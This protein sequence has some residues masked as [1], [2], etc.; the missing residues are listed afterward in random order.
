MQPVEDAVV[1]EP[2]GAGVEEDEDVY[3]DLLQTDSKA[4]FDELALVTWR[5]GNARLSP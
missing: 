1:V 3:V 4:T 5:P 2:R